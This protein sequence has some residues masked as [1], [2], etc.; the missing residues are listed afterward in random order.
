[1]YICVMCKMTNVPKHFLGCII[2]VVFGFNVF[3]LPGI[4][5][6]QTQKWQH[7]LFGYILTA[8]AFGLCHI[9]LLG[10]HPFGYFGF[11]MIPLGRLT[12]SLLHD[13]IS[14]R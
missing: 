13:H 1:M 3:R 9:V 7:I 10:Y 5:M 8:Q 6:P 14:H 2:L 12:A 4:N 11:Y